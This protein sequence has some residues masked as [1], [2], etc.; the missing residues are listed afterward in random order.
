MASTIQHILVLMLEN[1][2]FDHMLGFVQHPDAAFRGLTGNEENQWAPG[3]PPTRVSSNAT[4]MTKPDPGHHHTNVLRQLTG[5]PDLHHAPVINNSGFAWDYGLLSVGHGMPAA[6]GGEIMKC[7]D[8]SSVP[9]LST[10]ATSFA[11]CDHWFCS[12][13]GATWPNRN[14][15][16]SATSDG[17]VDIRMKPY[18]NRTIFELLE[19][20]DRTWRIYHDGIPQLWAFPKLWARLRRRWFDSMDSLFGAIAADELPDFAFVEPDHFGKDSNSQHPGNNAV[21]GRDFV[22]AE[23]LIREIYGAL[24]A[25]PAVF[26]KT[27]LVIT[28]DEHGGYYDHEQPPSDP[29]FRDGTVYRKGSYRFDFDLLGPRVPAVLVSPLIP[30]GTIVSKDLDHS[31]IVAT[32]RKV[33]APGADPLTGRD[34]HSATFEDVCSLASPRA[35]ADM[36]SFQLPAQAESIADEAIRLAQT[37]IASLDEFQQ[38]LLWLG[39]HVEQ[40]I[41]QE[42]MGGPEAADRGLWWDSTRPIRPDLDTVAKADVYQDHVVSLFRTAE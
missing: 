25:N 18:W 37:P 19:D 40:A 8:P 16:V 15:A 28:Y 22:A 33:F 35:A 5:L 20:E 41:L 2:S 34:E 9:V 26:E 24:L 27:L 13:P 10:L 12:V 42:T 29:K 7:H 31:A 36:P 6:N 21:A 30:A 39:E 32:A 17:Q 23:T 3:A 4:Y 1:R 11:V 14:F 38:S